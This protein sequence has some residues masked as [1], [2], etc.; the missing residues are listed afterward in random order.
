VPGALKNLEHVV[1]M[2]HQGSATHETRQAMFE[3]TRQNVDAYFA[4]KALITPV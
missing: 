1:L 3:L 2:P 4:G